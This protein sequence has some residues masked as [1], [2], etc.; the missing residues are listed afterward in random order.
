MEKSARVIQ[1]NWRGYSTR[2]RLDDAKKETENRNEKLRA[3]REEEEEKRSRRMAEEELKFQL[4]LEHRRRQRRRNMEL[5]EIIEILPA[6][7][8]ERYFVKQREYSA[9][10]IQANYRGYRQRKLFNM[11]LMSKRREKAAQIIQ[12]GVRFKY[13]C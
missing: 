7:Q 3:E 10:I 2:K 12:R 5:A 1:K 6:N 4:D 13:F 11:N 8:I 9:T